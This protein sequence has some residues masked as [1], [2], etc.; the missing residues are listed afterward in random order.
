MKRKQPDEEG[1]TR[2]RRKKNHEWRSILEPKIRQ[3]AANDLGDCGHTEKEKG[4]HGMHRHSSSLKRGG[5]E[6]GRHTAQDSA[7]TS[8]PVRSRLPRARR[9]EPPRAPPG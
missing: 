3:G 5:T 6:G 9:R 2:R 8:L 7:L 1:E 4:H